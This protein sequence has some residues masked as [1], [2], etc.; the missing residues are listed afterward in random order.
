MKKFYAFLTAA[1][2][3]T[4]MVSAASRVSEVKPNAAISHDFKASTEMTATQV[5][6][7][8][9]KS[10]KKA[11]AAKA[12]A[13][14]AEVTGEYLFKAYARNFDAATN[15]L[16]SSYWMNE[17]VP[18]VEVSADNSVII[19]GLWDATFNVTGTFDPENGTITIPYTQKVTVPTSQTSTL[20]L[21]IYVIDF[22]TLTPKDLV[23]VA[24]VANR[25]LTWTPADDGSSY[26]ETL[27]IGTY[28][29]TNGSKIY[30][31]MFDCTF[32]RINAI[33][34]WAVLDE[35]GDPVVDD[36]GDAQYETTYVYAVKNAEGK[37]EI[38]NF[39]DFYPFTNGDAGCFGYPITLDVNKDEQTIT[40]TN[41]KIEFSAKNSFRVCG[42]NDE[43]MFNYDAP[44]VVF[45][46]E[47]QTLESG[48]VIT[49][50]YT[51]VVGI[52]LVD[53]DK[54][55]GGDYYE[56][57]LL[58]LEP[59]FTGEEQSGIANVIADDNANAPVEYFN[60]QGIRVENPTTGIYVRR[61]GS[62]VTKVLVK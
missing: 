52:L 32:D 44:E 24:D 9:K 12:P 29:Y 21:N 35:N 10:A 11:P 50:F 7:M 62:N 47:E 31:Q 43:M 48:A 57:E 33:M 40:A 59:V 45:Y 56:V 13:T 27:L 23:L 28:G 25:E 55:Y 30:D 51:P 60:L 26:L 58:M 22:E 6:V 37:V 19:E 42:V 17:S 5:A 1:F 53:G 4:L 2:V 16:P 41:Q 49:V 39:L 54:M 14:A 20:D 36:N 8:E 61:Q 46:G 38:S 34:D 18:Y 3:G 15:D